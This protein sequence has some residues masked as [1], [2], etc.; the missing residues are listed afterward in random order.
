MTTYQFSLEWSRKRTHTYTMFRYAH[1][2]NMWEWLSSCWNRN[3]IIDYLH[4]MWNWM[5]FS[6]FFSTLTFV[7]IF[8]FPAIIK[9]QFFFSRRLAHSIWI[10]TFFSN[11][12]TIEKS[13]LK[14]KK[15]YKQKIAQM[16]LRTQIHTIHQWNFHQQF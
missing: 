11:N 12:R 3:V 9:L 1:N 7:I 2:N 15:N 8:S 14:K 4:D 5:Y 13:E 6:I 16:E 10:L